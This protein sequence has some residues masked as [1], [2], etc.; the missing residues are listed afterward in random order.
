MQQRKFPGW[1]HRLLVGLWLAFL[2]TLARPSFHPVSAQESPLPTPT[3]SAQS[4]SPLSSPTPGDA[5]TSPLPTPT[6]G[7]VGQTRQPISNTTAT[8]AAPSSLAGT[9]LTSPGAVAV[10]V[11][12]ALV[13]IGGMVRYWQRPKS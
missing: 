5:P 12:A 6:P 13:V 2:L 7:E 8:T 3:A 4:P 1:R 9:A 10:I 11:L